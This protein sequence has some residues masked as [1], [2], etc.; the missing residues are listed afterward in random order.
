MVVCVVDVGVVVV[1]D[2]SGTGRFVDGA[3]VWGGW[4]WYE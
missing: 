4:M 3:G 2:T 1:K